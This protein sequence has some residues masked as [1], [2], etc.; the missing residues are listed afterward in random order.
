MHPWVARD[1]APP[2]TRTTVQDAYWMYNTRS[3]GNCKLNDSSWPLPFPQGLPWLSAHL[4]D[5]PVPL[6]IYNGPQ[7][8]NTTYAADWPLEMSLY[9]NQGWG[10]GVLSAIAAASSE[11]FYTQ[12]FASARAGLALGSFTQ[13]FLDFQSLL[14]P[15]FLTD[16]R[17]NEGWLAGQANAALAA[18]VAVQVRACGW[19]RRCGRAGEACWWVH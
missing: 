8:G 17:G 5:P 16:P 1:P 15:G 4:G 3:N 13:D 12:F 18:G 14:F 10:S 11:A 9:W 2:R 19:V 7:C 6:I